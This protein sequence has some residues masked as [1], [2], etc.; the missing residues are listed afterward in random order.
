MILGEV[1]TTIASEYENG[2]RK[3]ILSEQRAVEPKPAQPKQLSQGTKQTSKAT[4]N[5]TTKTTGA[6]S[7]IEGTAST[8]Q[9]GSNA[10]TEAPQVD[11]LT[12]LVNNLKA[13]AKDKA[14][15]AIANDYLARAALG[16]DVEQQARDWVDA[17]NNPKAEVKAKVVAPKAVE[18]PAKEVLTSKQ[19]EPVAQGEPVVTRKKKTVVAGAKA[20]GA[21]AEQIE[22]QTVEIDITNL[23]AYFYAKENIITRAINSTY[24][25]IQRASEQQI[26]QQRY[27]LIKSQQ[28][29]RSG[30]YSPLHSLLNPKPH[31]KLKLILDPLKEVNK[32]TKPFIMKNLFQ[33]FPKGKMVS[34]S[35]NYSI[36]SIQMQKMPIY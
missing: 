35:L 2:I 18:E 14:H 15:S 3:H 19:D 23:A 10:G 5:G 24:L 20:Q 31:R 30:S 13:L 32:H 21:T 29:S 26:R 33:Q 16:E 22:A 36:S 25:K 6:A 7:N 28:H 1:Q 27:Q 9:Q 4:G 17:I 8:E 34:H 12:A 11:E